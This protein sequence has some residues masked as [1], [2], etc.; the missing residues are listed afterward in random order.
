MRYLASAEGTGHYAEKKVC[1]RLWRYACVM[2]GMRAD[3]ANTG[4]LKS[5]ACLTHTFHLCHHIDLD[6]N[7]YSGA[8]LLFERSLIFVEPLRATCI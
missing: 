1:D 7:V 8:S 4:T 6:T 3:I 2:H 5:Q